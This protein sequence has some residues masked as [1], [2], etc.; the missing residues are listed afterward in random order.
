MTVPQ[1]QILPINGVQLWTA[2]E[3]AGTPTVLCHGAPN[4][5]GYLAPVVDMVSDL[6]RGVR[7]DQR[8]SG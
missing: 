3:G 5:Y 7:Y 6:C 2:V 1:E 4:D 8:G